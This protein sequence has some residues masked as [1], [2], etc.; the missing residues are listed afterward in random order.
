[1]DSDLNKQTTTVL[2]FHKSFLSATVLSAQLTLHEPE[3][4]GKKRSIKNGG[5]AVAIA[6]G[7]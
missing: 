5:G 7:N 3:Q 4:Q 6:A 2:S 1:M